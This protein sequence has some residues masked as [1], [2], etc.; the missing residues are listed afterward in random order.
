M[1]KESI[2][3]NGNSD[4][5]NPENEE[6][7]VDEDEMEEE[8]DDISTEGGYLIVIKEMKFFY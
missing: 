1:C 8:E 3:P 5:M 6:E 4:N 7:M 2:P